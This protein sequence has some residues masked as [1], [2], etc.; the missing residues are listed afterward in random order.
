MPTLLDTNI[1]IDCLRQKKETIKTI[2][3]LIQ[4][5]H[6]VISQVTVTE[7]YAGIRQSELKAVSQYLDIFLRTPID[8]CVS[9]KAGHILNQSRKQ[10][11]TMNYQD[12]VIAASAIIQNIPL[13]TNN[14]KDFQHIPNLMLVKN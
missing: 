13:L 9:Q 2:E 8:E 6:L 14:K 4:Y 11:I 12:S 5:D 1:I 7:I 3:Q 10:G